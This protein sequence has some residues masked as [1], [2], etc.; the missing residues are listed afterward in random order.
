M[1]PCTAEF[2]S[3]YDNSVE[4]QLSHLIFFLLYKALQDFEHSTCEILRLP[5]IVQKTMANPTKPLLTRLEL[6]RQSF[7]RATRSR[8]SRSKLQTSTY[9][10]TIDPFLDTNNNTTFKST[11]QRGTEPGSVQENSLEGIPAGHSN[12]RPTPYQNDSQ[13]SATE[14]SLPIRRVS[15]G[16]R[17]PRLHSLNQ[18]NEVSSSLNRPIIRNTANRK[19]QLIKTVSELREIRRQSARHGHSVAL[20][21]TMGALHDGHLNLINVAAHRCTNIYVSIYLNPTQFAAHEDLNTYPKTLESDMRK[22]EEI[23][24]RLLNH[25]RSQIRA[26][27]APN[28]NEMY[29]YR[30]ENTSHLTI[31]PE[32][33]Q[34]LEGQSRPTFF[35]GVTTVVSKLLNIVQPDVVIFGQKDI[36]QF[37]V[38]QRMVR[39]FHIPVDMVRVATSRSTSGVTKGLAL[40]SRNAYLGERRLKVAPILFRMLSAAR[41]AYEQGARSRDDLLA[42]AMKVCKEE[43]ARQEALPPS[44]RV[45]F[46]VDYLSLADYDGLKEVN[47]VNGLSVMSLAVVVQ[48]LEMVNEGEVL[49]IDGDKNPVRLIDNIIFGLPPAAATVRRARKARE[50]SESEREASSD[51]AGGVLGE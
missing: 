19:P 48:P 10:T 49:G 36:Q 15:Y 9:S 32:L 37:C 13:S 4:T 51:G 23:N 45:R 2:K 28:S 38:V 11:V 22:L 41:E 12:K 47:I 3:H 43:Q 18:L 33:T 7:S 20:V 44:A 40:S 26:V 24:A 29:P 42:A 25:G 39:E 46:S 5:N 34:I 27:F 16:E 17:K 21:P 50:L 30:I 35:R 1:K 14:E 6:I 31:N 8:A